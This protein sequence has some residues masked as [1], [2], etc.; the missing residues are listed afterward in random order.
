[1]GTAIYLAMGRCTA[2]LTERNHKLVSHADDI[3]AASFKAE[4]RHV[5]I[6]DIDGKRDV[7]LFPK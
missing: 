2:F 1:M 6:W 3:L 7:I 4:E 5:H